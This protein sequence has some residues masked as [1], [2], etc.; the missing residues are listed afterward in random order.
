MHKSAPV[1][2]FLF[3]VNLKGHQKFSDGLFLLFRG[4]KGVL[5]A[6]FEICYILSNFEKKCNIF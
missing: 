1:R 2:G 4:H 3:L 5:F 6:R